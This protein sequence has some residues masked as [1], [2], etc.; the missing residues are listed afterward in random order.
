MAFTYTAGATADRDRLR[1]ELGDTVEARALFDDAELDDLLVQ[2]SDS[3]LGAAAHA[4]EILAARFARDFSFMADGSRFE[5]GG[6]AG[7]SVMYANRAKAL[8]QRAQGS[9]TEIPTRK[10]AYSDDISAEEATIGTTVDWDRG[11]F[12]T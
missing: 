2:E 7:L 3:V 4:C 10:D 8:R 9:S 12:E 5:K 11:R 6:A 1:F